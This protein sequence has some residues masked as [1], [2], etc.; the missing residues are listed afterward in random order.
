MILSATSS[1]TVKTDTAYTTFQLLY[2]S[3]S[4]KNN[5]HMGGIKALRGGSFN[6][7][8]PPK[9]CL[10]GGVSISYR[11]KGFNCF[12]LKFTRRSNVRLR[13]SRHT[14]H[15]GQNEL[16]KQP[17]AVGHAGFIHIP[18]LGM[19][20]LIEALFIVAKTKAE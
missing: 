14:V 17:D 19:S 11:M 12:F 16:Y 6:N 8:T 1:A 9:I 18:V 3:N 13:A 10:P 15:V 20:G 7:K 5:Q 2:L 4:K